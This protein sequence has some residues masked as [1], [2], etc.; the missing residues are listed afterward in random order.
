MIMVEEMTFCAMKNK[1]YSFHTYMLHL[2]EKL[3]LI[4]QTFKS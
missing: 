4:Y 2:N 1:T 3:F